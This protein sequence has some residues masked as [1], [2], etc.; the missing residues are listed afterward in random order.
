MVITSTKEMVLHVID[1]LY[2][3][4]T[5]SHVLIPSV[6]NDLHYVWVPHN[7]SA[8]IP[9]LAT[10]VLSID[11]LQ[12]LLNEFDQEKARGA[13][14]NVVHRLVLGVIDA[15]GDVVYESVRRIGGGQQ[16]EKY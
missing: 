11:V 5:K 6:K 16:S 12:S 8:I 13:G 1:R 9:C 4:S 7:A 14:E 15:S 2:S 3:T 10:D